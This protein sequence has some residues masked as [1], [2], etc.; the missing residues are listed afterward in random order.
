MLQ[1]AYVYELPFGAGKKWAQD[2]AAKAILGGW[3]INGIFSAYQGGH[4]S[5]S[6][7]GTSL[8]MPGNP[9]TPDQIKPVVEKLGNVGDLPFFDTTAFARITEVRF[10]NVGLYSM[11]GPGVVSMDL[12]LFRNFR[13]TERVNAEF[14]VESFNISN[15]PHFGNP[16]G[17][18]TSSNFGKVTTVANDPRSFRFGL[19]ITY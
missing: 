16:N 2:G 1:F 12:S 4:Y 11:R 17:S 18:I 19:R 5:L 9:Q 13:V 14:R 6:A 3:Q 8:N 15:T 7:S 10:G